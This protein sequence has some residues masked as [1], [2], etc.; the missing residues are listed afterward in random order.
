MIIDNSEKAKIRHVS[1]RN[2]PV[3]YAPDNYAKYSLKILYQHFT[4]GWSQKTRF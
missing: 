1:L 2:L 3:K 4:Y